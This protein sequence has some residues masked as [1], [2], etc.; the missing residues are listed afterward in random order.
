M[1]IFS[2][3]F[4]LPSHI[5]RSKTDK[6]DRE[7][8]KEGYLHQI[9]LISDYQES[10]ERS[11]GTFRNIINLLKSLKTNK[12]NEFYEMKIDDDDSFDRS[13]ATKVNNTAVDSP[14][15]SEI[16][17]HL[18]VDTTDDHHQDTSD[19]NNDNH[20]KNKNNIDIDDEDTC[21]STSSIENNDLEHI[22]VQNTTMVETKNIFKTYSV[23]K[24]VVV[25]DISTEIYP[26]EIFSIVG[27]K[28]AGKSTLMKM[29]YGHLSS[30][31]GSISING[32]KMNYWKWISIS[33]NISIVPKGDSIF[34]LDA[35]VSDHIKF[36]SNIRNSIYVN[37][38]KRHQRVNGFKLLRELNFQGDLQEKIKNLDSVE[39]NKVK[40]VIALIK[41]KRIL[42]MEEP[43]S[44]MTED[45]RTRFWKVMT[46]RKNNRSIII[47]T[48]SLQE[49]SLYA[50]SL[51]Y[52]EKGKCLAV[53]EKEQV[54][55][56]LKEKIRIGLFN[57]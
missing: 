17:H 32:R 5:R 49:A 35:T 8:Y 51:L 12:P 52:M 21:N 30:S 53:G 20:T 44:G 27:E 55:E 28:G 42:F 13:S 34:Y 38:F 50:T 31:Y 54:L 57:H 9:K 7:V 56:T 6:R 16:S 18:D 39:R 22:V 19:N 40:V 37:L 2:D 41:N 15:L 1:S 26:N 46:S 14:P 47:S 29:M 4:Y 36:Y 43:T 48:E 45:D 24:N 10:E 11:N 23:Y 25:S 3:V 33:K